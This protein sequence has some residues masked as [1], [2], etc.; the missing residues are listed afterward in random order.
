M[1]N[2]IDL[3][4]ALAAPLTEIPDRGFSDAVMV[5]VLAMRARRAQFIVEAVAGVVA[6]VCLAMPF[7]KFG[8]AINRQVL[9]LVQQ[10][11]TPLAVAAGAVVVAVLIVQHFYDVV[12]HRAPSRRA[13]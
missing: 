11:S 1:S 4:K 2:A 3:D 13:S 7:T 8:Q 6:L 12:G 10:M 5:R 9:D